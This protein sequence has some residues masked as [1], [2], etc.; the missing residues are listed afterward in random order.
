MPEFDS[1]RIERDRAGLFD[2]FLDLA[3]WH[4]QEIC[5]VV[6][7][8]CDQPGTGDAVNMNVRTGDPFHG[9]SF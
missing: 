2:C 9:F 1:G 5:L 8:P 4:E 6:Y 7:E 3:G